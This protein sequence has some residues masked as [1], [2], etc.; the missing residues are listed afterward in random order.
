MEIS[1]RIEL[2]NKYG[3]E[4]LEADFLENQNKKVVVGMSG[5][6]DSSVTALVIKLM[7][8]QTIGMFM[9]NWEE[10][11]AN[12][13]CTAE[14]D[15]KDV[16]KVCEKLDIP[17]YSVNFSQ[18]YKDNVF[19]DFVDE[20]KAGYTPNPDILCNREIK[21]KVFF[22]HAMEL[23]AD[24]L[25]T[26][27]YCQHQQKDGEHL[28]VKGNDTNKDQTYFLYTIQDS[29]LEKVLFP[30]GHLEKPKVR[31]L[32]SLYDLATSTK[33]DSTGI[34]FIGERNFKKFLSQYIKGQ[35][36]EFVHLDSGKSLGPHD[37]LC[38]YTVGQRKGLGLG[39]PG[40]PWFVASKNLEN[41]N[42]LVVE[43]DKHPALY[44]DYLFT[45]EESWVG[46]RPTFPLQCQAKVRYRQ[47]DQ[48]CTI[49]EENNR[50]KV[51][52]DNPQRAISIRQ[53]VVFYQNDICLGGAIIDES[54][55]TYFDLNK[56]LP[57]SSVV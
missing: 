14:E 41:N 53:S 13:V 21:F 30:L 37:G 54:A 56:E 27:H 39:G 22:N 35:K 17:Y 51:V 20:Y 2:L 24:Y 36:G 45:T 7:G 1:N 38:F 47:Q 42:V 29:V 16:I 9:R 57:I 10:I 23:G 11:D 12:G 26:G 48:S 52:F 5:G 49:Y 28:L 19:Q 18:E 46:K 50:L 55:P 15:Y 31:E 43:G 6:V 4:L 34:C 25:A 44:T 33:K 8:Y 32:A 3:I 40:G